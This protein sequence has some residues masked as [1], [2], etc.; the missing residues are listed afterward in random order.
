MIA[1]LKWLT[2]KWV[3]KAAVVSFLGLVAYLLFPSF[4]ETALGKHF[5]TEALICWI[6]LMYGMPMLRVFL[7]RYEDRQI[8]ERLKTGELSVQELT[9]DQVSTLKRLQPDWPKGLGWLGSPTLEKC[10]CWLGIG[11]GLM[12]AVPLL[13]IVVFYLLSLFVS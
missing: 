6:F 13:V 12:L 11:M 1:F 4:R 9:A 7:D 10:L 2:T 5:L 3:L 8:R